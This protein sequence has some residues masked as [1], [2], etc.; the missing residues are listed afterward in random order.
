[1][2]R[3][4]KA[5]KDLTV[6]K[7]QLQERKDKLR[8]KRRRRSRKNPKSMMNDSHKLFPKQRV[9]RS[10]APR[11]NFLG[12]GVN[13]LE[14]EAETSE[15]VSKKDT[16]DSEV[17][18][19]QNQALY[20]KANGRKSSKRKLKIVLDHLRDFLEKNEKEQRETNAFRLKAMEIFENQSKKI[21]ELEE[22]LRR[23]QVQQ[24]NIEGLRRQSPFRNIDDKPPVLQ[25]MTARPF[26][27][28][29][30]S[31]GGPGHLSDPSVS[32]NDNDQFFPDP[33]RYRIL[34]PLVIRSTG[35][36]SVFFAGEP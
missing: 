17:I 29:T 21:L 2:E 11:V 3:L 23:L 22:E 7:C 32:L 27:P 31:T 9:K 34:S 30:R 16:T 4:D 6:L 8:A 5:L 26:K 12:V 25:T 36:G 10:S 18:S 15:E 13:K 24:V 35:G 33:Y 28:I 20:K 14:S 19:L 1:M